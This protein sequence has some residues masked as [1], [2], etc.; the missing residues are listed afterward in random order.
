M[1]QQLYGGI[2]WNAD[3]SITSDGSYNEYENMAYAFG[4]ENRGTY[5]EFDTERELLAFKLLR[6]H[7]VATF[8]TNVK[9]KYRHDSVNFCFSRSKTIMF[10]EDEI[11]TFET[12]SDICDISPSLLRMRLSYELYIRKIKYDL[13]LLA[14][15]SALPDE[16]I[17][18]I[19]W[20]SKSFIIVEVATFI[21][22]NPSV[23]VDIIVCRF[24]SY[25]PDVITGLINNLEENNYI[26]IHNNQCYF[27]GRN[28]YKTN[29]RCR[30]AKIWDF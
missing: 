13:G 29:M 10:G 11:Q 7:V 8:E 26:G 5:I 30:W 24:S 12:L 2:E 1:V 14:L 15:T 9:V 25:D 18:E 21:Y 17:A 22:Q 4:H 27:I 6:K 3:I 16:I 19:L 28:P 23:S 20:S